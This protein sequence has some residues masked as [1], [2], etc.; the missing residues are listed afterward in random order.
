MSVRPAPRHTVLVTVLAALGFAAL[1]IGFDSASPGNH[2]WLNSLAGWIGLTPQPDS[3]HSPFAPLGLT[4][5]PKS[6]EAPFITALP[7]LPSL[8][9]TRLPFD[10]LS[11]E[12][13]GGQGIHRAVRRAGVWFPV[14]SPGSNAA[15]ADPEKTDTTRV[16]LYITSPTPP[17][18]LPNQNLTYP[19]EAIGGTPPYRWRMVLGVEGFSINPS[20]GLLTG[21]YPEPTSLPLAIHVTDATGA[22]D[23][24][25]YTLRISQT[26]P[27]TLTTTELPLGNI[28]TPYE[29]TLAASGGTPPY[30]W[31]TETTLPEGFTLD[32]TSGL[33][34]G[35]TSTTGFDQEITLQVTDAVNQEATATLPFRIEAPFEITTPNNLLPAA[36]G[37]PYQLTFTTEG[38][39][40]PFL[41]SLT[42]GNLPLDPQSIPWTLSPE[43][44]LSGQASLIDSTHRF[45]LEAQDATGIT[46]RK[47]FTL[48]VRRSLIVLPSHEKAGLAWQPRE[49]S[50]LIGSPARAYTVTRTLTPDGT[51]PQVVYQGSG[52]NFVDHSLA[53]TATYFYTLHAHPPS[54]PPIPIAT[55][56]A[57]L[58]PFTTARGK[59]GQ[60]ADPH[61]DA[62][63]I[64]RPL[65]NGGHGSGF[66]PGNVTGP[67]DGT[68]TFAPASNPAHV[69]SLHARIGT[70]GTNP[71]PFG[72]SITL[73]FEDN[74]IENGPGEDFTVFENVFFINGDP[75]QRF[76]EPAIVSVAL[77]EDQWY[78][79]PIDIVP[80]ATT[81]STTPTSDP[82]YYNRGFAGRNA[83]T[84]S[85]PTDPRQSGGDSFDLSALKIPGITWIRYI[86]IQST[87]HNVLRDDFGGHPVQHP[88]ILGATSG[89]SSSGFDLDAITAIHY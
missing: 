61:A 20:T 40:A 26:D 6:P 63:K 4:E 67:P 80:P 3:T 10:L 59:P 70:P 86:K 22:E 2:P 74:L 13:Q 44:I 53:T 41:W 14:F 65:S 48:P 62:V 60:L 89:T 54:G 49:I 33:L 81:S 69:L 76:M 19:F 79:F 36:P 7:D 16:P 18:T 8:A 64:F 83:T 17:I 47:T 32:P 38:G 45:T 11:L 42:E 34:S 72:G 27:L 31:S 75:N 29:T 51:N 24:A 12:G 71:D 87:G 50:T 23:S 5:L 73:A 82:F 77:F 52:T 21:Q 84:G 43:G 35:L 28:G 58:R 30:T 15:N 25:L 9:S 78:R 66:V 39:T 68:G 57:T 56:T 46:S 55:T 1:F 37:A 85:N 88:T